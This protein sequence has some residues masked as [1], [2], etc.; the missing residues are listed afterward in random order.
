MKLHRIIVGL[1]V[2][3]LLLRVATL[4]SADDPDD[5]L[6]IDMPTP[7]S[8][9][10]LHTL[11]SFVPVPI[12]EGQE[13]LDRAKVSVTQLEFAEDS[14]SMV[15]AV[16]PETE[17]PLT[18]ESLPTDKQSIGPGGALIPAEF[19]IESGLG[20]IGHNN[21]NNQGIEASATTIIVTEDFES[22]FSPGGG[23]SRTAAP[24]WDDVPCFPAEPGFVPGGGSGTG[25]A[26]AADNF[27]DPAN[28]NA[29]IYQNNMESWLTYG[30]FS[31]AD[32]QSAY[33]EFFFRIVSESCNPIT[34]CD[35]LFWGA[36]TDDVNY[37]GERVAGTH[38]S[39][40]FSNGHN[41]ASFNLDNWL[42]EP[43]VW[44]GFLFKSN[45]SIT[46][47]GP[48]IDLI[49]LRKNSDPAT[50][51]TNENFDI[52]EFPNVDW[53]SIDVGGSG[54]QWDDVAF[55]L[56]GPDCPSHSGLWSIWPADEGPNGLNPCQGD[57]YPNN[58][59]SWM[60]HG[61]FSLE[62]A[63]EAWIDFYFRNKSEPG[64]DFLFWGVSTNNNNFFGDLITGDQTQGPHDNGYNLMRLDLSNVFTLGDL[65]G[66][67]QVWLGF[68]FDSDVS[69][70]IDPPFQGPFI[71]DVMITVEG[72]QS[73]APSS[74]DVYLPIIMK[75]GS[76]A[77]PKTNLFVFNDNAS[78]QINFYKVYNAKLNGVPIGNLTCPPIPAKQTVSCGTLDAGTYFLE[79]Q[80]SNPNCTLQATKSL[81]AGNH[82]RTARCPS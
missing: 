71:D 42:G 33:L 67:S 11:D 25:S 15:P 73:G 37:F 5:K 75:P 63:N 79:F 34:N 8:T 1:L 62:G 13:F 18:I 69:N 20:S 51:L 46:A 81:P 68:L 6:A 2:G 44:I 28:C 74:N 24:V 53:E 80:S 58:M 54:H 52:A 22:N 76:S 72:L 56:Q 26:W 65:R 35:Y 60:I 66:Q 43:Q 61:P 59:R 55:M 30:P 45:G 39:G 7:V 12:E 32:A 27:T 36:S 3:I 23:W 17:T 21:L 29:V 64:F 48:F 9:P 4:V 82:T 31:L 57:E 40:P 41:F 16:P 77:F 70:I 50:Y 47:Q 19:N 49:K 38:T 10:S 78:G 14:P